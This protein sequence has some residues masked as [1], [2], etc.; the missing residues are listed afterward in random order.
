MYDALGS[1]VDTL[2]ETDLM[3]ELE[4]LAVVKIVAVVQAVNYPTMAAQRTKLA[5]QTAEEP[6]PKPDDEKED[7]SD[8]DISDEE[9]KPAAKATPA[10]PVAEVT[11]ERE[12]NSSEDHI[13]V[14]NDAW[15]VLRPTKP[16]PT[17]AAT[18]Q[19]LN[20]KKT[21]K[22]PGTRRPTQELTQE[23]PAQYLAPEDQHRLG[24]RR[25][26]DRKEASRQSH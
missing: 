1:K 14:D 2:S 3:V 15:K 10:Y 13:A 26:S 12:E 5:M 16:N 11:D 20:R 23:Y 6:I 25:Q 18:T 8:E 19:K 24:S 17:P 9:E 22:R 7:C 21:S 4:N